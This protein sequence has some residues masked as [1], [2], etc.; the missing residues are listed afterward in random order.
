MSLDD[1]ATNGVFS[2]FTQ[3][4]A[5]LPEVPIVGACKGNDV[6]RLAR[7][8]T[9]GLRTYVIRD[10]SSDFIFMLQAILE[11]THE[12]AHA[13]R[14]RQIAE[15]LREQMDSV[16]MLQESIIP[17]DVFSPEGYR[18]A[19]RYEPSQLRVVGGK[20]VVLA[21]RVAGVRARSV[22]RQVGEPVP[23]R[24]GQGVAGY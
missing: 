8:L 1:S 24:V 13:E 3:L 17:K 5:L 9:N 4:R 18:I 12:A 22:L 2:T 19:A 10:E 21:V 6:Y 7:F 16:R 20:P 11:S 15:K 14:E 23:V